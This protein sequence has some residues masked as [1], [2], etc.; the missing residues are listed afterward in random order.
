YTKL[1]KNGRLGEDEMWGVS[2]N[3]RTAQADDEVF[4]YTGDQNLGII[5]YAT[6]SE[7]KMG[8]DPMFNLRFDLKK[9]ADLLAAPVPAPVVRKWLWPRR[10]VE[11]LTPHLPK[12]KKFLP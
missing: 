9:C 10:A 5:G 7:V 12:L 11:N 6:I 8:R 1:V 3:F 4:I 2:A